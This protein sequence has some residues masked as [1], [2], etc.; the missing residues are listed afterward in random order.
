MMS[1]P[2][3]DWRKANKRCPQCN[4]M[5]NSEIQKCRCGYRFD[6]R[7]PGKEVSKTVVL[8]PVA[9][10]LVLVAL[11]IVMLEVPLLGV[12]EGSPSNPTTL[13]NDLLGAFL[14]VDPE[15]VPTPIPLSTLAPMPN[16]ASLSTMAPVPTLAPLSTMELLPTVAISDINVVLVVKVEWGNVR[17]GPGVNHDIIGLVKAGDVIDKP[18]GQH[19]NGWYRF[20]CV[21]GDKPGWVAPSLVRVQQQ[22]DAGSQKTP[23]GTQTDHISIT[24]PPGSLGVSPIYQ[25]YMS[26]GGAHILALSD[27]S[28]QAMIQARDI[29]YGMVSTRPDLLAAMTRTGLRIIIF[30][31]RTTSLPQLPEFE[32]WPLAEQRTGGFAKDGSGYTVAA[33]ER[34]LR[35]DRILIHE[36]AHAV[37]YTVQTLDS[38]FSDRR[39]AAYRNALEAGLWVGE[40]AATDK[41]EYWAVAVEY[42]FHSDALATRLSTKDPEAAELVKS[43]FGEARLP[44]SLCR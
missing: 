37:D 3:T 22:S 40:Y 8:I 10:L 20:C 7:P 6:S 12:S 13:L 44:S 25:K 5:T 27:V 29:L 11:A 42:W 33:P 32:E 23:T 9:V 1:E 24:H 16:L 43:V 35:C 39:D 2:L 41:H 30:D 21:D 18:L 17:A 34:Y 36:I 14:E 19:D 28:D 31:E 38:Q 4:R 26:A 15:P